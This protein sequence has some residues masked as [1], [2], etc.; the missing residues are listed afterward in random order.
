MNRKQILRS[1]T[2]LPLST[3]LAKSEAEYG[4]SSSTDYGQIWGQS[5]PLWSQTYNP[6]LIR[7]LFPLDLSLST[8]DSI[9]FLL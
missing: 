5:D 3:N 4:I 6:W 8:Y 7:D 2:F 9:Y 1:P